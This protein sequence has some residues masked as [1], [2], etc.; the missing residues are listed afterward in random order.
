MLGLVYEHESENAFIIQLGD[1]NATDLGS[2]QPSAKTRKDIDIGLE[3]NAQNARSHSLGA[4]TASVID[5][6]G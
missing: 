3:Y 4:G 6:E 2:F 1:I 5:F